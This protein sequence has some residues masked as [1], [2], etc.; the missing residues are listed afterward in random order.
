MYEAEGDA[1]EKQGHRPAAIPSSL[2]I[3]GAR[4]TGSVAKS[5]EVHN[6]LDIIWSDLKGIVVYHLA[7]LHSV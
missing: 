6:G 4:R 3:N 5:G 7:F 2:S 1:A